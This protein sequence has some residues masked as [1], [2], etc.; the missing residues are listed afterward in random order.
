MCNINK[1]LFGDYIPVLVQQGSLNYLLLDY[2]F[3]MAR[4]KAKNNYSLSTI[5]LLA[6]LPLVFLPSMQTSSENNNAFVEIH[7]MSFSKFSHQTLMDFTEMEMAQ[8]L[9]HKQ[10][11]AIFQHENQNPTY[12]YK[13]LTIILQLNILIFSFTMLP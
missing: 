5:M 10:N 13:L 9:K 8:V 1:Y 12:R 7:P 6:N 11:L 3:T 4:M 2:S